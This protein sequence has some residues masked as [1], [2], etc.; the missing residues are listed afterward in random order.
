MSKIKQ[1]SLVWITI[2]LLFSSAFAQSKIEFGFTAEGSLFVPGKYSQYSPP[3]KNGVSAGLGVYASRTILGKLSAD[4]GIIYRIKQLNEYY[5]A[6]STV[7][8]Y[9]SYGNTYSPYGYNYGYT[10][11]NSGEIEGWKEYS[12]DYVVVPIHL[13][14]DIHKI[15]FL[16][17]GLEASWLTNFKTGNDNT[18]LNW[19][20][21]FGVRKNKLKWTINYIR[22]FKDV[23]FVNNLWIR[24]D[25]LQSATGYRNNMLQLSLSYPLWMKK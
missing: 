15:Y 21:G 19:T 18:E 5:N 3:N 7:G 14:F 9:T 22:G 20:I 24:S 10:F 25:G 13:K 11:S 16:C 17:G 2:C 1:L 12:L 6:L 23:A 8:G 4:I